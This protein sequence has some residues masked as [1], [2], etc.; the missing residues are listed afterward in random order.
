MKALSIRQPWAWLIANGHK[1]IENRDWPTAFRGRFL[2]HAG[3]TWNAESREDLERVRE[4]F[5]SL[6]LPDAFDLGGI[7][8]AATLVA[9][10]DHSD[11]PWFSGPFGFVIEGAQ[12]LELVPWR[13]MLG[14]FNVPWVG[15][16]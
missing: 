13:G 6:V 4:H 8:G 5:P 2:V 9:C 16:P 15:Q 10:T 7:V 14:F 11:S 1:D 3:K 12:P